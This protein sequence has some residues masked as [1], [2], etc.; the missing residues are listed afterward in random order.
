M[1]SAQQHFDLIITSQSITCVDTPQAIQRIA[2]TGA[3][4]SLTGN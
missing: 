3:S 1:F 4:P 2:A